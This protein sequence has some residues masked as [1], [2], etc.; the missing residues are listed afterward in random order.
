MGKSKA[1]DLTIKMIICPDN[2]E[3]EGIAQSIEAKIREAARLDGGDK[4]LE[5]NAPTPCRCGGAPMIHVFPYSYGGPKFYHVECASC[6]R[7]IITGPDCSIKF[8]SEK[9]AIEAWNAVQR[10]FEFCG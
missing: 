9:D 7:G 10:G 3:A 2:V 6:Y 8:E 5:G 1:K 4:R